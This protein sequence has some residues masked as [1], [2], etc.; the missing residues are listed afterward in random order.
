MKNSEAEFSSLLYNAGYLHKPMVYAYDFGDC[1]CHDITLEGPEAAID[2]LDGL[3]VMV[4]GSMQGQAVKETAFKIPRPNQEQN[5]S[6]SWY[7]HHAS[8][9]NLEM[10]NTSLRDSRRPWNF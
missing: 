4:V 1:W 3:R 5:G 8:N 9:V 7:K 6:L 10:T 2:Y